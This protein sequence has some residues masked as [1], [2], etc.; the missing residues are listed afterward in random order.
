M[1]N[2]KKKA[3]VNVPYGMKIFNF[4]ILQLWQKCKIKIRKLDAIL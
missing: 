4:M 3:L 2:Y 1:L